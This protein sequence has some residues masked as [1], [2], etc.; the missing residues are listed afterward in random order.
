MLPGGKRWRR[1]L[2]SVQEGTS[3]VDIIKL[4]GKYETLLFH[5]Y[6]NNKLIKEYHANNNKPLL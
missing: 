1:W 5:V 6:G 3:L 4:S 2:F